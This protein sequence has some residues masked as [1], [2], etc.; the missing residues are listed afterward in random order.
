MNK[1]WSIVAVL[2]IV[3]AIY[4]FGF[5]YKLSA[6]D[7]HTINTRRSYYPSPSIGRFFD[8]KLTFALHAYEAHLF[9]YLTTQ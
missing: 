1:I 9:H 6:V 4:F 7:V 8:N 5:T 2:V 3:D